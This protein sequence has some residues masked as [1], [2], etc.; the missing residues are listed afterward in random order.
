MNKKMSQTMNTTN[1]H[2]M[3]DLSSLRIFQLLL[4]KLLLQLELH[5]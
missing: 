3:M 5:Q 2:L 4:F 1:L